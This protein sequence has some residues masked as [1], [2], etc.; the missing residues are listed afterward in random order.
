VSK[1]EGKT[2]FSRR[3]EYFDGLTLTDP[4]PLPL[5]LRQL[6]ATGAATLHCWNA[7]SQMTWCMRSV[8]RGGVSAFFSEFDA[9]VSAA[10]RG[11][12]SRFD[13]AA[14]TPPIVR[15]RPNPVVIRTAGPSGSPRSGAT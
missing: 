14:A 9:V 6:Y 12:A 5:I 8:R 15:R 1:M 10:S 3:L 13:E 4:D 2:N 11:E 7:V